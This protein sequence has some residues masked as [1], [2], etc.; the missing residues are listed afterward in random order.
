MAQT[1]DI[2]GIHYPAGTTESDA[3]VTVATNED[4]P[5]CCGLNATDMDTVALV[6]IRDDVL[7][8][9]YEVTGLSVRYKLKASLK[10]Y[11]E[12]GKHNRYTV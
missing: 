1:G 3:I 9:G 8:P 12:E 6:D 7:V 4:N 2:V 10:A 5:I 11:V